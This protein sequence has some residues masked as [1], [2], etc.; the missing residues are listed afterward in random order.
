M[1]LKKMQD[2]DK[3]KRTLL[4]RIE[5]LQAEIARLRNQLS[6]DKRFRQYMEMKR[7]R[8]EFRDV[9]EDLYHK[10]HVE[11]RDE[12]PVMTPSGQITAL[13]STRT[14]L[15]NPTSLGRERRCKSAIMRSPSRP[16]SRIGCTSVLDF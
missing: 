10:L 8:D 13:S 6:S 2:A 7:E 9:S 16:G 12:L 1:L 5:D 3:E 14:L 4:M 11:A 15:V